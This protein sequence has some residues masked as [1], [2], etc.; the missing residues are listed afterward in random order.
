MFIPVF[1]SDGIL[2][3]S[4]WKTTMEF[5]ITD[6]LKRA[7][8]PDLSYYQSVTDEVHTVKDGRRTSLDKEPSLKPQYE[9]SLPQYPREEDG[10][11]SLVTAP[12]GSLYEV[13]QLGDIA[14]EKASESAPRTMVTD[15]ISC[16]VVDLREANEL[17]VQFNRV[18]N[19]YLWDGVILVHKDLTSVRKSSSMYV[20]F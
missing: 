13:T 20:F 6:L 18:L 12:M 15:F 1:F 17:F 4:R 9:H 5:A 14:G 19:H 2:N 8:L 16:G 11:S 10:D 3:Q 7:D